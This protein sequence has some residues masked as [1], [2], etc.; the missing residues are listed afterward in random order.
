MLFY[1]LDYLAE[2]ISI[3]CALTLFANL[4]FIDEFH[5]FVLTQN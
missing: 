4:F 3:V 5:L 2:H 1:V